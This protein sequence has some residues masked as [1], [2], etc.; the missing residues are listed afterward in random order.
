[1]RFVQAGVKV[2]CKNADCG[3]EEVT[4]FFDLDEHQNYCEKCPDCEYRCKKCREFVIF[5][6][7]EAHDGALCA[8]AAAIN[9]VVIAAA[10]AA[11]GNPA[12]Q[13]H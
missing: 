6:N 2:K 4:K 7:K 13:V 10:V 3:C 1:M 8:A 11:A 5:R 12:N 9:P